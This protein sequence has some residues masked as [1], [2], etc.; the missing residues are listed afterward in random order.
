MWIGSFASQFFQRASMRSPVSRWNG[1]RKPFGAVG[2]GSYVAA[3]HRFITVWPSVAPSFFF[4]R[5]SARKR[6]M[7]PSSKPS[8]SFADASA[9]TSIGPALRFGLRE[10]GER[11]ERVRPV[12]RIDEVEVRVARVVGDR[13]PRLWIQHAVDDRAVAARALAEAAAVV[14]RRQGA[15]LRVDEG[16]ELLRQVVG[17]AADRRRVD[18]LVAA[19]RR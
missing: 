15:E 7:R 18:V 12:A 16:N 6:A 4:L 9:R 1:T 11:V 2:S 5:S 8:A 13:T 19:E 14:A 3:M 10:L 17:V